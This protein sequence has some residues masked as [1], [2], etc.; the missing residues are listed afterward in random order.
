MLVSENRPPRNLKWY[1]AG[2]L[3][4]GDWGTSRLY[5]LG[6]AF[7][8]TAHASVLYLGAMS[9]IMAAVAWA[10]TV[11]CRCFPDG[12]G[13]YS[14][15]RRLSPTLAVLGATLLLCDYI[16]T[17]ALSG[18]EAFHY[19]GVDS[20]KV[21]IISVAA[22]GIIGVVNWLGA[23]SAGRLALVIAVLSIALSATIAI[24]CLPWLGEGI[25]RVSLHDGGQSS[26]WQMWESLVRIVLALSGLE[27][28]AN[29]TGLMKQPVAKTAKRTIWPV[30]CEVV[31]LNL[32]F[33]IALSAMPA[34]RDRTVPDYVQYERI[35]HLAPENVPAPVK[36]YRDTAMKLVATETAS[37]QFGERT[38]QVFGIITGII[39]SLLLL[40]AVNTA[41]MAMV[42]VQY[43]L[44]QDGELPRLAT[45]LNYSGVPWVPLVIACAAP[46]ILLMV[47]A[48]VKA[49]GELYAIGVVGAITINLF[50][51]AANKKLTIGRY[52]RAGLWSLA[53]LMAI[54]FLTIVV[55]KP[56]ATI[57]AGVIVTAVLITRFVVR[58]RARR[59]AAS[60]LPE[61]SLGWIAQIR[62]QP[63]VPGPGPR[64]MLAARGRDQAAFAVDMAKRRKAT[65]FVIFVR[66]LRLMDAV[67]GQVPKIEDDDAAQAALGTAAILAREAGL[68]FVP[69]YVTSTDVVSEI[70]DYTVTFGC[71]TLIM[72][73]SQRT[74]FSRAVVGDVVAR[75]ADNLPDGVTL[76]TRAP[77]PFEHAE[78]VKPANGT[79][80]EAESFRE[81]QE[82]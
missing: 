76:L 64:I 45:K 40:S 73:K 78:E 38:G 13:V 26:P 54:I 82:S 69:I 58:V 25:K 2:P 80:K 11:V 59:I 17:A 33:G 22:I 8:Y 29:M 36:E 66:T 43:S 10:Y 6:L 39:F 53:A 77:G 56:N 72:G 31:L 63:V 42:S 28:V 67:P 14:A 70:L 41:V 52:E 79:H 74:P 30:L 19:L 46:A 7:Y 15:A 34:I 61:P 71:D 81:D 9:L 16:V 50:S 24:L 21:V 57:F 51:C 49:L 32:I 75:V 3:L 48:D 18:I 68:P 12:G 4:F 20:A 44:A 60:P 35:E 37:R 23:R 5:V 62:D 27:A 65:L 47:E 55:A 1:H